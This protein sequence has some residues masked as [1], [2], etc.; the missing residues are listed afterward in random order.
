MKK[1][2]LFTILLTAF[3]NTYAQTYRFTYKFTA[4]ANSGPDFGSGTTYSVKYANGTS[5]VLYNINAS[6]PRVQNL[7][8]NVVVDLLISSPVIELNILRYGYVTSMGGGS[9]T[10][11]YNLRSCLKPS[12]PQIS[13]LGITTNLNIT[14]Y[15]LEN[16]RSLNTSV[17]N[18]FPECQS[19][20]FTAYNNCTENMEYS[21]HYKTSISGPEIQLKPFGNHGRQFTLNGSDFTGV[22][23]NSNIFIFLRYLNNDSSSNNTSDAIILKYE[24]CSPELDGPVVDIQP[25]CSNS[26]NTTDNNNGSFTITFDREL[27]AS[28]QEKMNLQVF[29]QIGTSFDGY[30]SK[31]IQKSDFSGRSYTW[32]PRNLPS[33]TYKI[34]WQTKSNNQSFDN[35][36]SVPD[37]YD[38]SNPFTLTTPPILSVT[39]NTSLVQC[40][41]GNDGSITA[42]P[43]GGTP[44]YQYSI[45]NGSNWQTNTLFSGLSK[46]DYTLLVQD[47]KG[48]QVNSTTITVAERFI[49]IPN[50]IN[51]PLTQSPTL[52][53]GNNGRIAISVTG[54]SGS[55]T[56][57]QWTKD[58]N[59]FSL[60]SGSTNTNLINLFEGIYTVTV[61]D[62]NGCDSTT[63]T[64][65]LEDPLPIDIN[66]RMTPDVV[67]CSDSKV[68][69]IASATEGYL[70]P[71]SD[72]TYLWNDGTTE[73]TLLNV[74]IG[75]YQVI[76]TDDGGN[77]QIQE[78]KVEGPEVIT[79]TTF[80]KKELSCRNGSDAGIKINITGGTGTYTTTW[81]NLQDP[82]FS[83]TGTELKNVKAGLYI[84]RIVD[85][86]GCLA[87]NIDTPVEFVNPPQFIIDL[88]EDPFF[89]EGQIVNISAEIQDPGAVYSWTS[90]NGFTS[91]DPEINVDQEGTYTV[92]VTSGKGCVAQD[93]IVVKE[94]IKEIKAEFL[95]ANQVFTNEKFVI[96]DVTFP[97]PDQIKWIL[98]KEANVITQDQDLTELYFEKPGEYQITMIA[99]LGDCQ[100]TYSQKVLVIEGET[101]N[102]PEETQLEQLVNIKQ[103]KVFP[104]PSSGQFNIQIELKEEKDISIK[105]FNLADNSL[106]NQQKLTK[107]NK[108]DIPFDLQAA[109]G[110]Y[111]IVLETPYGKEIR[112]MIIN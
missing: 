106:I 52:I 12:T 43:S 66:I 50:V 71:G 87:T 77:T 22:R 11:K 84:Y 101:A 18:E 34:F 51:L 111:A 53:D 60:P 107:Q 16:L 36:N 21:V 30:A 33:G 37:A 40:A 35:I 110:V 108:Y 75:T 88:G 64:F 38:E 69:L 96:I 70:N 32:T 47:S 63:Q 48:C 41:G 85:Q 102:N 83:T 13:D 91:T 42:V 17:G 94:T 27:D 2:I 14:Q 62:T 45:D 105:I 3:C 19:K 78:F 56:S 81:E 57:Y 109:S 104:N 79:V 54:G 82:S 68:N 4:R 28:K 80:D 8:E 59:P 55:Y 72:Y 24:P 92:T 95:Y 6:H 89:C 5:E 97:I 103:F 10:R 26:I 44:P 74:G 65:I 49:S 99:K 90:D 100:D 76:V 20:T 7:V 1:I 23:T 31:V 98:P 15:P 73:P 61:T 39:G 9:Q 67:D 112:K 29:R 93:S 58:G 86:N 25:S 46:G